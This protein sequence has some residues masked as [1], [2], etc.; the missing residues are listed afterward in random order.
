M[1]RTLVDRER[2]GGGYNK[3]RQTMVDSTS[4]VTSK[5]ISCMTCGVA[6]TGHVKKN[7]LCWL[8]LLDNIMHSR[9]VSFIFQSTL[10]IPMSYYLALLITIVHMR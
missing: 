5:N 2:G 10:A 7:N 3:G 9:L 8:T 4:P 6:F 1:Y